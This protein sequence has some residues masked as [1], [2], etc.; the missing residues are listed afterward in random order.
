[1][2][3]NYRH[4]SKCF[5]IQRSSYEMAR[6]LSRSEF[7]NT[8]GNCVFRWGLDNSSLLES[9]IIVTISTIIII[10]QLLLTYY[11]TNGI[12]RSCNRNHREARESYQNYIN[13]LK[14]TPLHSHSVSIYKK[15]FQ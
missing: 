15:T 6:E 5:R 10:K 3:L 14:S 4:C 11:G 12:K 9:I 7:K 1:M 2:K 13:I 8:R